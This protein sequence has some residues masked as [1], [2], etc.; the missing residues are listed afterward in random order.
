MVDRLKYLMTFIEG[1]LVNISVSGC[2]RPPIIPNANYTSLTENYTIG[3]EIRYQCDDGYKSASGDNK[4]TCLPSA[5]WSEPD[6]CNS[7][8][9]VV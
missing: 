1:I 8:F 2:G 4:I 3:E 7:E 9:V 6:E 5:D